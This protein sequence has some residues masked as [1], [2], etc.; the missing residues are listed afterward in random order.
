MS[1]YE[2]GEELA[3]ESQNNVED[4]KNTFVK[5]DTELEFVDD[6]VWIITLANLCKAWIINFHISWWLSLMTISFLTEN[7]NLPQI[8]SN[9]LVIGYQLLFKEEV[10]L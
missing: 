9:F 10:V 3:E 2:I 5:E 4:K 7:Y 8:M 6:M 1:A